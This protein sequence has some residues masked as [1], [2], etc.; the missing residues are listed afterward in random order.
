MRILHTVVVFWATISVMTSSTAAQ[1]RLGSIS[2][3]AEIPS[4]VH[5]SSD[6]IPVRLHLGSGD[7]AEISFPLEVRWNVNSL[8]TE[9]LIVASLPGSTRA[10]VDRSGHDIPASHLDIAIGD[11]GRKHFPERPQSARSGVLLTTLV[12]SEYG[13]QHSEAALIRIRCFG[14]TA[15]P[16]EYSGQIEMRTI[17]R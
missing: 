10:L 14:E 7:S 6:V 12:L 2:L 8:A 15:S 1:Q 13:R 3:R 17:I 11:S 4:T 5:L 9:I 16:G